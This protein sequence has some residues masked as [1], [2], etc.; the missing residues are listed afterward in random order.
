MREIFFKIVKQFNW[1]IFE[2]EIDVSFFEKNQKYFIFNGGDMEI[3]F[4][5]CKISHS[6]RVF[7]LP[8]EF[9]KKISKIDLEKGFELYLQNDEISNR[10]QKN[11][12]PLQMYM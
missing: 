11:D 7:T 5:K 6:R 12:Y 3:L 8:E 4:H 1:D 9:K 2:N 10:F